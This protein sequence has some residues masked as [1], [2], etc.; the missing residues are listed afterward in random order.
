MEHSIGFVRVPQTKG[1]LVCLKTHKLIKFD[2]F[3]L[4]S[5]ERFRIFLK[6]RIPIVFKFKVGLSVSR[7]VVI[8]ISQLVSNTPQITSVKIRP[9]ITITILHSYNKLD[10]YYYGHT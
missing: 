1:S 8:V 7:Y 9:T 10:L 3:T 6:F 4:Q 5:T 2:E